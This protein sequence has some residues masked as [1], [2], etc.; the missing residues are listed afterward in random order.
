MVFPR[1]RSPHSPMQIFLL[2]SRAECHYCHCCLHPSDANIS[3]ALGHSLAMVNKQ[4]RAHPDAV[5]G[6]A[7]DFNQ[8]CLKTVLPNLP[9]LTELSLSLTWSSQITSHCSF[10]AYTSE[11]GQKVLFYSCR[12]ALSTLHGTYLIWGSGKTHRNCTF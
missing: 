11:L 7:G 2:T 3:T 4:Q 9:Q 1:S 10:P 8:A 12:A 6:I 5:H